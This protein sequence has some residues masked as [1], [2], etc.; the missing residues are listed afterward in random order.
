LPMLLN[1]ESN[2]TNDHL[3]WLAIR[4]NSHGRAWSCHPMQPKETQL[5]V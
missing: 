4:G 1:V 3:G 2:T 5:E